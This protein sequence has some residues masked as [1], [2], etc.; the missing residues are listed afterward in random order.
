M[1]VKIGG[2]LI[3][4]AV[5]L[6]CATSSNLVPDYKQAEN[7][8]VILIHNYG[9]T[10]GVLISEDG[11]VLSCA[12][13]GVPQ[14]AYAKQFFD[15]MEMALITQCEKI[16][17]VFMDKDLD[18]GIYKIT[19]PRHFAAAKISDKEV[20]KGEDLF[21]L[22]TP[23]GAPFYLSW[24]KMIKHLYR[25]DI[26]IPYILHSCC[27][28]MGNSGGPLFNMDGELVGIN[29]FMYAALPTMAGYVALIDGMLAIRVKDFLPGIEGIIQT[30]RNLQVSLDE[31]ATAQKHIDE[32]E[33]ER[34]D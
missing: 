25:A 24:G 26:G 2:V 11:Y 22:G 13:G 10:S 32:I 7:S 30:H 5:L 23:L 9:M 18:I 31:L 1:K 15:D 34:P 19:D 6:G 20:K 28:N 29:V 14:K 21:S 33:R 16:E 4:L 3:V 17:V 27:G 12:H 8:V